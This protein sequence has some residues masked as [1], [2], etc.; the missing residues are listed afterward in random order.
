MDDNRTQYLA[1]LKTLETANFLDRVF[2][3][4][5]GFFF[6]KPLVGTRITP[7]MI[8]IL[9]IFV[10]IGAGLC[11]LFSNAIWWTVAGILLLILA[12]ILDCV[13]GQLARLT[14]IKSEIGRILDGVAGD[15]WFATIYICL[16][17]RLS[18]EF[19]ELWGVI[20]WPIFL[21]LG[22]LSG[23]SHLQQAAVTDYYKTVHLFFISPEKG[24]EL[25]TSEHVAARVA[26]MT[27]INRFFTKLYIAYTRVQEWRT[28][29]LQKYLKKINADYP[30]PTDIPEQERLGYRKESKKIIRYVNLLSF[31]GRTVPLFIFLLLGMPWL[32][33]IY[34][35]VVLNIVLA[36]SIQAHEKMCKARLKNL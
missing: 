18:H 9:S 17:I 3:R 28:P 29:W 24:L 21:A 25:E 10:G 30:N 14:G 34:E 13:D 22:I 19:P 5:V 4:P 26:S 33:F 6:T 16:I 8:T 36:L 2:Y 12:N 7:N 1:S 23:L 35:I 31:N 20:S 27:G 32:Y 11:F 15:L